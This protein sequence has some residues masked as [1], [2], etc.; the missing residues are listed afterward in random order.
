MLHLPRAMKTVSAVA[1]LRQSLAPLRAKQRT[2]ALVPT[3]GALHAGHLSLVRAA[4]Q[5][6]DCV[7]VSIFVN[8]TQFAPHEDLAKYPRNLERDAELLG[9]ESADLLF[10]PQVE[11]IYPPGAITW[12]TVEGLDARNE[13]RMRPGHYRGVATVVAKLFNIVAPDVALFGQKDAGQLALIRRMTHDLQYPIEI[14]GCPIVR[15]SD[16]LAMSSRNVYLSKTD[17]Q[18][19]LALH[20]ALEA[21]KSAFAAGARDANTIVA[22]A[23]AEFRA[24]HITPDYI[25][26]LDPGSLEPMTAVNQ[27]ALLAVAA[28]IGDT[29]LLDN[30]VLQP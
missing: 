1:E 16:G 19:A 27:P 2:I 17:R 13:G 4:R 24:A 10:T 9:A 15:E 12:V 8:P 22:A 6:A 7:V 30:T 23:A 3:M 25:E 5:R 26:L 20:C 28:K 29:R 14:V 21:A 11:E 18:R